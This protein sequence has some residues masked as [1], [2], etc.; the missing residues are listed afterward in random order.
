MKAECSTCRFWLGLAEDEEGFCRR[1]PP[2]PIPRITLDQKYKGM[3]HGWTYSV[4]NLNPVTR[5]PTTH[6]SDLCGEWREGEMP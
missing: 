1:Y 6:K 3:G 2:T 5:L 4:R